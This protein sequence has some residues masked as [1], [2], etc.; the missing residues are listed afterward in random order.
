M[1]KAI[2]KTREVFQE[3]VEMGFTWNAPASYAAKLR[4]ECGELEKAIL[5]GSHEDQIQELGDV[6]F[7]A[8]KIADL[9]GTSPAKALENATVKNGKRLAFMKRMAGARGH[10]MANY[11]M[12]M[13]E[14]LWEEAKEEEE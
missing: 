8:I 9:I 12:D 14:D 7:L 6:L 3:M 13:R 5:W 11:T 4:A 1:E 2:K 10:D